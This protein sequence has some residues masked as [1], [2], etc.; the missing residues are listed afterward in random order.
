MTALMSAFGTGAEEAMRR[1]GIKQRRIWPYLVAALLLVAVIAG[2]VVTYQKRLATS[3][4]AV[5]EIV[6]LRDALSVLDKAQPVPKGAE[7]DLAKLSALVASS[8]DKDVVRWRT[9]LERVV[10]LQKNL[11]QLDQTELPDFALRTAATTELA[12]YRDDVGSERR[13]RQALAG[14]ARRRAR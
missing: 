14:E 3:Q 4:N 11:L 9:K 6:S 10:A 1:L 12:K 5:K 13:G 8:D 2:G 7:S